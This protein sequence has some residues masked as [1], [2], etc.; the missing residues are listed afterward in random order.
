MNQIISPSVNR[1]FL[2]IFQ[3]FHHASGLSRHSL[4][5]TGRK[6]ECEFC[7]KPFSDKSAMKRHVASLHGSILK[8]E[9]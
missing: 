5:H 4:V 8:I 2:T 9:T 1:L 6:F 3:A 7:S